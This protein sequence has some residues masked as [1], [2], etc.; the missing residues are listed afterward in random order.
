M[1]ITQI[2][3][4]ISTFF[5]NELTGVIM[6]ATGENGEMLRVY[7]SN[8]D[9]YST[10]STFGLNQKNDVY[11]SV[12]Y[13]CLEY[14]ARYAQQSHI[15]I[16]NFICSNVCPPN[17]IANCSNEERKQLFRRFLTDCIKALT[18]IVLSNSE[19]IIQ[20]SP[21]QEKIKQLR[22]DLVKKFNSII[23]NVITDIYVKFTK[24]TNLINEKIFELS[25]QEKIIEEL[26]LQNEK[27]QYQILRLKDE[28][29]KLLQR[30]AEIKINEEV[31]SEEN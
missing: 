5:V 12:K 25:D 24:N 30:L 17:V 27:L 11:E 16:I 4:I 3:N 2:T 15:D 22:I 19:K 29:N 20:L 23:N 1:K 26:R 21:N 10:S 7:R 14:I 6:P 8:V 18:T 28:N 9:M 31:S 13:K